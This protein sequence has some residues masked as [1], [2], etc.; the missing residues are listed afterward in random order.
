MTER[1]YYVPRLCSDCGAYWACEH[2]PPEPLDQSAVERGTLHWDD[3]SPRIDQAFTRVGQFTA[4]FDQ[5]AQI[6]R[7]STIAFSAI[8]QA[9]QAL[10]GDVVEAVAAWERQKALWHASGANDNDPESGIRSLLKKQADRM[11]AEEAKYQRAMAAHT[12]KDAADAWASEEESRRPGP[13]PIPTNPT[14]TRVPRHAC[15]SPRQQGGA[16]APP[17]DPA[18]RTRAR[19][20]APGWPVEVHPSPRPPGVSVSLSGVTAPGTVWWQHPH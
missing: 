7:G 9:M 16:R 3:I 14:A 6:A 19:T 15:T 8:G 20:R 1:P 11:A 5:M 4:A 10:G 2:Q 18:L 17:I 13:Q 12:F